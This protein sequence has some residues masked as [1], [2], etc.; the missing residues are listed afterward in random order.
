MTIR[1]KVITLLARM[2]RSELRGKR[3]RMSL[4]LHPGCAL[5]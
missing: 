4:S 5:I 2:E 3:S 1:R